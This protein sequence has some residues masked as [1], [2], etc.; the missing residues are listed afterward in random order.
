MGGCAL[1]L[2]CPEWK[3]AAECC[4][5]SNETSFLNNL[6]T[7]VI[8]TTYSLLIYLYFTTTCF[9]LLAGHLRVV[10]PN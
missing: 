3:Q 8:H 5:D 1:N 6:V 2:Y 9:D 4:E 7:V 10:H